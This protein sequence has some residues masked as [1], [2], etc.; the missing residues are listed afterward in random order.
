M[1]WVSD[2]LK[3]VKDMSFSELFLALYSPYFFLIFLDLITTY[4]GVCHFNGIELNNLSANL[5]YRYGYLFLTGFWLF[6]YAFYT[7]MT[8]WLLKSRKTE[9]W[10]V[11]WLVVW[12]IFLVEYVRIVTNNTNELIHQ[13]TSVRPVQREKLLPMSQGQINRIAESFLLKR[14]RFCR[15]L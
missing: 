14:E 15:L 3:K 11:F 7:L 8:T 6:T 10:F 2:S 5:G 9:I 12:S 1:P 4:I 13:F